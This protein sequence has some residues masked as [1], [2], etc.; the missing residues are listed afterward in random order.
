MTDILDMQGVDSELYRDWY[1]TLKEDTL[2]TI[3]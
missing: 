3:G 2:S 1:N